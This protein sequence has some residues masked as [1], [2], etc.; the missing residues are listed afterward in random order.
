MAF[1]PLARFY[2]GIVA[3]LQLDD[4]QRSIERLEHGQQRYGQ[5]PPATAQLGDGVGRQRALQRRQGQGIA[6]EDQLSRS[7]DH[8]VGNKSDDYHPH[9]PAR[10]ADR[11]H[12]CRDRQQQSRP[13]QAVAQADPEVIPPADPQIRASLAE[14]SGFEGKV[15]PESLEIE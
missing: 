4:A 11:L 13:A 6:H 12:Q 3:S 15:M 7:H 5:H 1:H 14:V 8:Q 10:A 2:A 9:L